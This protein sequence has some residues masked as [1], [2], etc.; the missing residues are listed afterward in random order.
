MAR[1]VE[2]TAI[3]LQAIAGHDSQDPT[4]VDLPVP[5]YSKALTGEVR[6][7]RAGVPMV[8]W[9]LGGIYELGSTVVEAII[10][11]AFTTAAFNLTGHL[12]ISVPCGLSSER[13]PIGLQIA[14]RAFDE[15]T[16]LRI[17]HAYELLSPAAVTHRRAALAGRL[18]L[19][20]ALTAKLNL[21][22]R[23]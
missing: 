11:L 6:G 15:E 7:L 3:I 14:G 20:V 23:R 19:L 4:T 17:A 9:P 18:L 13:L 12:A 8:A 16:M 5:E 1:T 21:R 22:H 2:D 10:N